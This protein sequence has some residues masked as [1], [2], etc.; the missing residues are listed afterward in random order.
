MPLDPTKPLW[1]LHVVDN[2]NGGSALVCRLHHRIADG[3]A[4]VQVL[5]ATADLEPDDASLPAEDE[6]RRHDGLLD[7]LLKPI[8]TTMNWTTRG[9]ELLVRENWRRWLT[10]R[11]C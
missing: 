4:L 5:L 8:T 10:R 7:K 1:Q 11:A 2:F 3:L 9:A 6:V